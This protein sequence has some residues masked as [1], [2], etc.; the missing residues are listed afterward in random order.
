MTT[1]IVE[2]SITAFLDGDDSLEIN[3]IIH[4]TA[5]AARFG[6]SGPLVGGTT[7][8]SWSAAALVEALGDAWLDEG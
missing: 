2:R 5:G 7:V 3:N 1:A 4:S 8:Y 6:Y